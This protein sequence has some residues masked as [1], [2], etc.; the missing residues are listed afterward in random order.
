M[1][2]MHD[3][4]NGF[5]YSNHQG[6]YPSNDQ[7]PRG[8]N[9]LHPTMPMASQHSGTHGLASLAQSLGALGLQQNSFAHTKP[10]NAH[11]AAPSAYGGVLAGPQINGSLY[12]N[13][14]YMYP[15]SF[16]SHNVTT[17]PS[18]MQQAPTM[19]SPVP[20][21]FPPT[22]YQGYTQHMNNHSPLS[23][24]WGSRNTSGDIPS[25]VTPRRDSISSNEQDQPGTP[26][27]GTNGYGNGIAVIDR[28]PPEIFGQ[29]TPSPTQLAGLYIGPQGIKPQQPPSSP[30][31]Q[32]LALLVKEPAIPR[33]IPAPSS[34]LK[35]L[36]RALQ[37]PGG[38]TNVYIRGL[39]PETTDDML[40]AW[41]LRFGDI[42]SSKSIIDHQTG[43]CKG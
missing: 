7:M 37:N 6:Q 5:A 34:P 41:G 39:Q 40:H 38:E 24:A 14:Q 36:D 20:P 25:L 16:M 28:T 13:G 21:Q 35:P 8:P 19:Y 23:T 33:A 42:K 17:A 3:R 9:F 30:S 29:H 26:Y 4:G 31:T 11:P 43:L 22:G 27:T 15:A 2:T 10:S 12:A 1:T 32:I 18:G